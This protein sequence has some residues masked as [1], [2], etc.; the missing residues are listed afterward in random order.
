MCA[1]GGDRVTEPVSL[2]QKV[3]HL[4]RKFSPHFSFEPGQRSYLL[5][6]VL[7]PPLRLQDEGNSHQH[8]RLIAIVLLFLVLVLEFE[9]LILC[10]P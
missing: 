6:S 7:G 1:G 9:L 4:I 10:S 8:H 3:P 2:S 5:I